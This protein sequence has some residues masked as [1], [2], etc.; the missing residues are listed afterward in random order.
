MCMCMHMALKAN[1]GHRFARI[2]EELRAVG[3]YAHFSV[4]HNGYATAYKYLTIATKKKPHGENDPAPLHS[5]NHPDPGTFARECS[6][7]VR[8]AA[9]RPQP[10]PRP[11]PEAK[12]AR[13]PGRIQAYNAVVKNG[14]VRFCQNA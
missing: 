11:E 13:V 1:M 2:A 5:A 6:F 8:V 3:I 10:A 12:K 9:P 7:A 14:F 4:K